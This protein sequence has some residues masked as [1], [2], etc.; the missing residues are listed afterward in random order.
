MSFSYRFFRTA[1][2]NEAY[3]S[4]SKAHIA[5]AILRQEAFD[6]QSNHPHTESIAFTGGPVSI[7]AHTEYTPKR[8]K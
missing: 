2:V 1:F 8:A 6:K 7:D 3:E 4:Y 5:L